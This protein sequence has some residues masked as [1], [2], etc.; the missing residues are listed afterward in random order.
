MMNKKELISFYSEFSR[1]FDEKIGSLTLY[2]ASYTDLVNRAPRKQ[3]LLDLACGPGNVSAFIKKQVPDIQ[4]TCVDLSPRM[5][6]IA[7]C[8]IPDAK[9]Y[10]SDILDINI[11]LDNYDIIVCGFGLPY[12][13]ANDVR[14]VAQQIIGQGTNLPR[15]RW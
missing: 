15:A 11:P 8:K 14:L 7:R 6:E 9:F 13:N 12:I 10:E 3:T 1:Q 2:D 4:V 5:L